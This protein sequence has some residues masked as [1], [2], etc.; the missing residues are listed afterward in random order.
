VLA[1]SVRSGAEA[2]RSAEETLAS[3][4]AGAARALR[5]QGFPAPALEGHLYRPLVALLAHPR[6]S[7]PSPEFWTA[8]LAVQMVHEASLLHDDVLDDADRRRDRPTLQSRAGAGRALLQGDRLL[9]AAYCAAARVGSTDFLAAFIEAVEATVAGEAA[10]VAARGKVISR[11]Q[12]DRIVQDKT[13]ALFGVAL[14]AATLLSAPE[15][16]ASG[17]PEVHALGTRL[18]A[19]FQRVDDF[20]DYCPVAATGKPMFGDQRQRKWTWVLEPLGKGVFSMSEGDILLRLFGNGNGS[21]PGSLWTALGALERDARVLNEQCA[22]LLPQA[23]GFTSITRR[24]TRF[25]RAVLEQQVGSDERSTTRV[26]APGNARTGATAAARISRDRDFGERPDAWVRQA[27]LA[28]GGAEAWPGYFARNSRTFQ[29]A[30]RWF[31]ADAR[32]QVTGLYAF[33]RFTDDL[34]DEHLEVPAPV[35][36]ARLD[37]WMGLVREAYDQGHTG[38]PLLD[39]VLGSARE[40]GVPLKYAEELLEGVRMDLVTRR[41]STLAELRLYTFRVASVVGGW[42]TE[43]FGTDDPWVLDRAHALGHAMQLTNILRDVGEDLDA[44]RVYLPEELLSAHGVDEP[45]LREMRAGRAPISE[46]YIQVLRVLMDDADRHY[47]AAFRAIPAL[48]DFFQKPV[49]VAGMVYRGIQDDLVKAGYDNLTRR[50]HTSAW[51]KVRLGLSALRRL[52]RERRALV[53]DQGA[54]GRPGWIQRA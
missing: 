3:G 8:A 23:P 29:F 2:P 14:S 19:L 36:A 13:G 41:Y 24:W 35:R 9:T 49:A 26:A 12:Y 47:E 48:P 54:H 4:L 50:A 1:L 28:V 21:G 7:E 31:P 44:D 15:A 6:G 38:I 20:L 17:A 43:L 52:R 32:A 30:S 45:L 42:M 46:G 16:H 40:R 34:V 53:A 33:C 39:D 5:T 25:C 51:T 11:D 18:G 27:A 37:A 10:Q 22:T